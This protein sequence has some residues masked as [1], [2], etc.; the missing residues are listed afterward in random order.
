M[1]SGDIFSEVGVYKCIIYLQGPELL[2]KAGGLHKFMNWD[3]ALLTVSLLCYTT[4]H[5]LNCNGHVE[6]QTNSGF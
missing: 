5:I 6:L 2:S 4:V 3:R 1:L